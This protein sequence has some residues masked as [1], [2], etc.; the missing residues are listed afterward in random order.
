ME[1]LSALASKDPLQNFTIHKDIRDLMGVMRWVQGRCSGR[2][3]M[4]VRGGAA[5]AP[6]VHRAHSA[7]PWIRSR[8]M[9]TIAM[10]RCVECSC[11]K[12]ICEVL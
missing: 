6:G 9:I 5:V 1:G 8:E 4:P 11:M 10:R 12:I 2:T 7:R 3:S